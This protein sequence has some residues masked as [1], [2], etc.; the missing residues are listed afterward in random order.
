MT[1]QNESPPFCGHKFNDKTSSPKTEFVKSNVQSP[2]NCIPEQR[3]NND[4]VPQQVICQCC[5]NRNNLRVIYQGNE[6]IDYLQVI[7]QTYE[8]RS[9]SQ[10][11]EL[12]NEDYL[13]PT[14]NEDKHNQNKFCSQITNYD[15]VHR[16][17]TGRSDLEENN[18]YRRCVIKISQLK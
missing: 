14:V 11:I 16:Q 9:Y 2:D 4:N 12:G 10:A 5:E 6:D 8:N 7:D 15:S 17:A 18:P 3:V 13:H 1:S